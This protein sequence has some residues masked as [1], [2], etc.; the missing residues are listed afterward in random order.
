MGERALRDDTRIDKHR[1]VS[2]GFLHLELERMWPRVW[3]LAGLMADLD[4]VGSYFTYEIGDDSIVVV[5]VADGVRAFH[6]VCLHRGRQLCPPG[7]GHATTFRC[8]YHHWEWGIDGRMH[9]LPGRESFP[10]ITDLSRMGLKQVATAVWGGFVW[11]NVDGQAE[12]LSEYLGSVGRRLLAY[13]PEEYALVSDQTIDVDC[14]WKVA[15]DASNESYHIPVVHPELLQVFDDQ[16]VSSHVI[17]GRHACTGA[18]FAVPSGRL[19][20]PEELNEWLTQLIVEAGLAPGEFTGRA[21]AVRPAIQHALRQRTEDFDFE[22]L[23]DDQLTD[24]W[25]YFFFPNVHMN[26]QGLNLNVS[27][28]RPHPSVP[29]RMRL[30]QM[31]FVR[32]PRRGPRPPRPRHQH[33]QRGEGSLGFVTDQDVVNYAAVQRGLQSSACTGIM[34]GEQERRVAHMH[35]VLDGYLARADDPDPRVTA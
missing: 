14:N 6:N 1:Y 31:V 11:V 13:R 20:D 3:Q 21:S 28:C 7:T 19:H 9:N 23:S 33:H 17:D 12:P 30:D 22:G 35:R 29:A 27:R 25:S 5:R 8:P 2:E 10:Q 18:P 4:R 34:L 32:F 16:H 15:I 24:Y 26:V